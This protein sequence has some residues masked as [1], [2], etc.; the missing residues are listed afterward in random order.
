MRQFLGLCLFAMLLIPLPALGADTSVGFSQVKTRG[1]T[2]GDELIELFNPGDT[3]VE[4]NGYKLVKETASGTAYTLVTF[5]SLQILPQ[6]FLLLTLEGSS[7]APKS[8]ALFKTA[9][10][11]N[12]TL[13]LVDTSQSIV[14]Q[15]AWGDGH[16][17]VNHDAQS[18]YQRVWQPASLS[19][20][21]WNI[22][23]FTN[24]HLS[25]D[26]LLPAP[27]PID[28]E[29]LFEPISAP[30]ITSLPN[31]AHI[32]ISEAQFYV[33][34][35]DV[36]WIEVV[37]STSGS[38]EGWKVLVNDAVLTTFSG[39]IQAQEYRVIPLASV[40]S[41]SAI[42]SLQNAS[43]RVVE[44]VSI[45]ASDISTRSYAINIDQTW[46]WTDII[47]AGRPNI[48]RLNDPLP[49][50]IP[51]A[52]ATVP[53][54]SAPS[55]TPIVAAPSSGTI[56]IN[57]VFANPSGDES[58]GEFI[59]VMNQESFE[60]SLS[61]WIIA[62]ASK[63]T[64]LPDLR[65]PANG[66]LVLHKAQTGLALN[67]TNETVRLVNTAGQTMTA[68]AYE[69]AAEDL[70]WNAGNPWYEAVPTPGLQNTPAPAPI[71]EESVEDVEGET[72]IH[73]TNLL[74]TSD[75]Q[76][77][78]P[79]QTVIDDVEPVLLSSASSAKQSEPRAATSKTTAS[80]SK[81]AQATTFATWPKVKANSRVSIVGVLS[82]PPGVFGEKVA[83]MQDVTGSFAGIELYFSAA[84]WPDLEVGDIVEVVGKKSTAKLGDRLLI[85][86]ASDISVL[87]H[88]NIDPILLPIGDLDTLQHRT[89]VAIDA[90]IVDQSRGV[91]DLSDDTGEL[92]ATLN[93]ADLVWAEI[94]LPSRGLLTGIYIHAPKPELWLR[95]DDDMVIEEALSE[96]K[97]VTTALTPSKSD[98][99]AETTI[100]ADAKTEPDSPW[101]APLAAAG[102]AGGLGWYFFQDQLRQHGGKLIERLRK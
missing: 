67:N 35:D 99:I 76:S 5:G 47:T 46:S 11:D 83:T 96:A 57:E 41:A 87:D 61:G 74:S 42:I 44:T 31:T 72:S 66:Y 21:T 70:S 33:P 65:V 56:T 59:E 37:A 27:A 91:L 45:P 6:S 15:V 92:R 28:E 39:S 75:V 78:A 24:A 71:L 12:N 7:F 17:L 32:S 88:I 89:L 8:D 52:P 95:Y 102:S 48:V 97:P 53:I 51:T 68:I 58:T 86:A 18:S 79:T 100:T 94:D 77:P 80:S 85:S 93:K 1:T 62:D 82:V 3:A 23:S 19:W 34:T 98:A 20:S 10:A 25:G 101:L 4:L 36:A 16:A 49:A 30:E 90:R 9:I 64:T 43:G 29:E 50:C 26:F 2:A 55:T 13:K 73:S 81:A 54:S 60:V 40:V 22:Q 38:L 14:D 63:Q 84:A 69:A